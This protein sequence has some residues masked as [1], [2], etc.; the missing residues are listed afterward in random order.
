MSHLGGS[1]DISAVSKA[2]HTVHIFHHNSTLYDS[3]VFLLHHLDLTILCFTLIFFEKHILCLLWLSPSKGPDWVPGIIL[4]ICVCGLASWLVNSF[5]F[6]L[7]I[8]IFSCCWK[9]ANIQLVPKNDD[10]SN[11]SSYQSIVLTSCLSKCFECISDRVF[12]SIISKSS[13]IM[14]SVTGNLLAIFWLS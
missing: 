11:S 10:R 7:S 14:N 9:P 8:S 1:T 2:K 3:W 4:R 12:K 13:I 6:C 5:S